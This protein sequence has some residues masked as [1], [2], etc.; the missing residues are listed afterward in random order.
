MENMM[1]IINQIQE[2]TRVNKLKTAHEL[3]KKVKQEI[4]SQTLFRLEH[5]I[6][7]AMIEGYSHIDVKITKLEYSH[8][9]DLQKYFEDKGFKVY[10]DKMFEENGIEFYIFVEWGSKELNV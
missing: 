3:Y 2:Q 10:C 5:E 9:E 1:N 7:A 4:V 8:K 6:V